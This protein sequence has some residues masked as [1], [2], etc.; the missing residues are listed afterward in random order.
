MCHASLR[1]E[2]SGRKLHLQLTTP[3]PLPAL[4]QMSHVSVFLIGKLA[5]LVFAGRK[6]FQVSA[7]MSAD[8]LITNGINVEPT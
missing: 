7:I 4:L 3:E 6:V 8:E 2:V 1:F 5:F